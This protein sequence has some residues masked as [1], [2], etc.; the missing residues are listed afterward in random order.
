M[1]S[2]MVLNERRSARRGAALRPCRLPRTTAA[3]P[4]ARSARPRSGWA[5]RGRL[6]R[7]S[8]DPDRLHA[9]VL[10]AV[11]ARPG[12]RPVGAVAL[13]LDPAARH[14]QRDEIVGDALRAALRQGDIAGAAADAVGMALDAEAHRGELR[15]QQRLAEGA[16]LGLRGRRQRRR[17]GRE[18]QAQIDAL[19]ARA[20]RLA[21][22]E[23]ET[24]R[25]AAPCRALLV[26]DGRRGRGAWRAPA[27]GSSRRR[28][29][30]SPKGAGAA[31]AWPPRPARPPPRRRSRR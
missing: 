20:G 7:V 16:R 31:G 30:G 12:Q 28:S 19:V 29:R 22:R 5:C 2:R 17:A 15:H 11:A 4:G 1:R 14:A 25:A 23:G 6:T 9:P 3:D 26:A 10:R 18:G 24:A 21:D 13:H 27:P 8:R